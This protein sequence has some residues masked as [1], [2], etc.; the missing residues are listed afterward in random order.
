METTVYRNRYN[1]DRTVEAVQLTETNGREVFEWTPSKQHVGPGP[2]YRWEGLNVFAG[3]G[4]RQH[5]D[6]GDYV[7]RDSNGGFWAN[8]AEVFELGWEPA[9]WTK[10]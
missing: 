8:G 2:D 4:S 7:Y 9:D 10:R 3:D 1:H 6:V 5:A